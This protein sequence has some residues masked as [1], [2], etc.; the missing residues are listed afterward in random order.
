MDPQHSGIENRPTLG[1]VAPESL[2][3][4]GQT[5]EITAANN[6]VKVIGDTVT[7]ELGALHEV[8]DLNL[9]T[10]EIAAP[11][12]PGLSIKFKRIDDM[13][14]DIV[15]S[16]NSTDFGNHVGVNHFVFSADG[17]TLTETKTHT[18]RELTP[19]GED[20]SEGAVIKTAT[21][22]LVFH[23]PPAAQ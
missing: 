10:G 15:L 5:F 17:K 13:A 8:F 2:T 18:Q 16:V 11:P 3:I 6:G 1:P 14:F 4:K 19:P 9:N 12:V 23:R 22:I 20:Q 7:A 21:S